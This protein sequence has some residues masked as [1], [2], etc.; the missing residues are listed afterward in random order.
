MPKKTQHITQLLLQQYDVDIIPYDETFLLKS[1]QKRIIATKCQNETDY[2]TFLQ[3]NNKECLELVN[4]L[5]VSYTEFFR[6]SLS[7][8]VLEHIIFPSLIQ[9]LEENKQKEIRIW[10][11]ACAGGQEAYS[12]A[13]LLE[14]LKKTHEFSFRIFATDQSTT[15]VDEAKQGIYSEVAVANLSKK[16]LKNWFSKHG[17]NYTIMPDLKKNIDFSVFDMFNNELS[18][19]PSSIYGS[20]DMVICANLLFYYK[21]EYQKILLTKA[22]KSIVEQ[23]YLMTGE[24][25]REILLKNNH[26]EVY[27]KSGIFQKKII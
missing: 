7:F 5:T 1:I 27:L 14:E 19:P 6:N 2:F 4:T 24:T 15:Q 9:K 20:F 26:T 17:N 23:G 18:T 3:K 12:V 16:R 8:A 22:G 10:C 25:E 21:P 11:A 13:M